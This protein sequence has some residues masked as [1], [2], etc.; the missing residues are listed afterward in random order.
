MDAQPGPGVTV[1][2]ALALLQAA[3]AGGIAL[4]A[5]LVARIRAADRIPL[6]QQDELWEAFCSASP[7]PLAGLR[8]GARVQVG[9]L[10][11]VGML[12]VTCE[13]LGEAFDELSAYAP[14]IGEGGSFTLRHDG[15]LAHVQFTHRF[16]VRPVERS[17]AALATL[18]HLARWATGERFRPAGVW[19]THPPL[20][21]VADYGDVLGCA[22]HFSAT[23]TSLGFTPDQLEL[24][25]AQA[26]GAL[27][28]HLRELADRTLAGLDDQGI[29]VRVRRLIG[30]HPDW[31][32]DRV[33]EHL[34]VSTRHLNRLLAEQGLTFRA[35]RERALQELTARWLQQGLRVTDIA[36]RLGYSDET[37]FTR[38]FRRWHGTTPSR[39][40]E[41]P[42]G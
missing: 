8:L 18:L 38:A 5:E 16:V 42:A 25:L 20:A 34:A 1:H 36:T 17:E 4:P 26:N 6:T 11:S 23:H 29:A 33:A 32:R 41:P 12:L 28:D 19:F 39:F 27:R 14:V 3:E 40:R 2:Y 9:H 15:A 30:E 22:T 21:P 37:A 10:D 35:V 13:T 24:P 31:G 7:D